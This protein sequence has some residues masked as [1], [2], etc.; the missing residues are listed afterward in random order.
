M[1]V[2]PALHFASSNQVS[3]SQILPL[4]RSG[5]FHR[6]SSDRRG[7][8]QRLFSPRSQGLLCFLCLIEFH[9]GPPPSMHQA[10]YTY[11]FEPTND[12]SPSPALDLLPQFQQSLNF[13]LNHHCKQVRSSPPRPRRFC[14]LFPDLELADGFLFFFNSFSYYF[15]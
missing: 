7:I 9:P 11:Q 15:S 13:V 10:L 4:G 3:T 6:L 8:F 5:N 14:V 2:P 1:P 12:T